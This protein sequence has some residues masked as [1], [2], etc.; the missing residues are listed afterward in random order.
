MRHDDSEDSAFLSTL[1][2]R[3]HRRV[4]DGGKAVRRLTRALAGRTVATDALTWRIPKGSSTRSEHRGKRVRQCRLRTAGARP[5]GSPGAP[6]VKPLPR[7]S[8]PSDDLFGRHAGG[9]KRMTCSASAGHGK[10]PAA[11]LGAGIA[12]TG[13][14]SRGRWKPRGERR[15]PEPHSGWFARYHMVGGQC[16]GFHAVCRVGRP[17]RPAPHRRSWP[18]ALDT[19]PARSSG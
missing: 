11:R 3:R 15:S 5:A 6:V 18:A 10:P 13:R 7:H 1:V 4:S 19:P 2:Q 14:T 8:G 9:R 16:Q 12:G 17:R